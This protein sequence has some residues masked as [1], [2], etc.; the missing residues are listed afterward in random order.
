[1]RSEEIVL[2]IGGWLAQSFWPWVCWF[3]SS[4]FNGVMLI[5]L[6]GAAFFGGT[7]Y[8]SQLAQKVTL[9]KLCEEAYEWEEGG[10]ADTFPVVRKKGRKGK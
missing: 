2:G 8:H 3:I 7:I 6:L 9:Q 4:L 1:M 5:V 10:A